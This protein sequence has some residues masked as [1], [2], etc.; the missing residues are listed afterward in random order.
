MA[1]NNAINQTS[2]RYGILS[3]I[4]DYYDGYSNGYY[5]GISE[6]DNEDLDE[7]IQS[8]WFKTEIERQNFVKEE[9]IVIKNV[10]GH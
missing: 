1:T 8:H 7:P 5:Y 10:E 4:R 2:K 9:N 3:H 6:F